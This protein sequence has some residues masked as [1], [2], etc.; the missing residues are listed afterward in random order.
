VLFSAHDPVDGAVS[1]ALEMHVL[2]VD[3]RGKGRLLSRKGEGEILAVMWEPPKRPYRPSRARGTHRCKKCGGRGLVSGIRKV[4]GMGSG[5]GS[6]FGP[7]PTCDGTGWLGDDV[8]PVRE[9]PVDDNAP[10]S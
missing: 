5:M 7:C 1:R 2:L 10:P 3:L 6:A 4:T 8:D 9:N